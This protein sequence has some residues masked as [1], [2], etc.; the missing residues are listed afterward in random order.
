MPF[1]LESSERRVSHVL[2][3]VRPARPIG[4][5]LFQDQDGAAEAHGVIVISAWL[6]G[7]LRQKSNYTG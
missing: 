1:H 5:L 3:A 6:D 7:C 2:I 4:E